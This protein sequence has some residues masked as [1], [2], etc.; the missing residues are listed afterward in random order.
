MAEVKVKNKQQQTEKLEEVVKKHGKFFEYQVV[1]KFKEY[2]GY[3]VPNDAYTDPETGN[4][5]E[6]DV[7]TLLVREI[8]EKRKKEIEDFFFPVIIAQA[9]KTSLVLLCYE[10]I[11]S[12]YVIGSPI[13]S[14]I[15]SKI[16]HKDYSEEIEDFLP[17]E[18]IIHWYKK[19]EIS[20]QA[21]ILPRKDKINEKEEENFYKTIWYPLINSIIYN[22]NDHEKSWYF[23]PEKETINLQMYYPI[24]VVEGLYKISP[25]TNFKLKPTNHEIFVIRY[26]SKDFQKNIIFDVCTLKGLERVLHQIEKETEKLKNFMAKNI[27]KLKASAILEAK[28][29]FF[30][31]HE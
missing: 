28:E 23:D 31:K 11:S 24:V 15:P 2:F 27:K 10:E 21:I 6:I 1:L 5:R 13:F 26:S 8:K 19:P 17:T 16:Y 29:R 20:T 14:G 12:K 18:E 25:F 30:K 3:I 22:V 4:S 7:S 9:K